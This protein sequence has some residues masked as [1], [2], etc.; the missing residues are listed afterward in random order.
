M[1]PH[2]DRQ[3]KQR[4]AD[5]AIKPD[6]QWYDEEEVSNPQ[7]KAPVFAFGET[8]TSNSSDKDHTE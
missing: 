6:H 7:P 3:S 4:P 1:N 8:P 2:K 5:P